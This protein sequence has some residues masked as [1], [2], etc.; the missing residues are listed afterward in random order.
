[1]NLVNVYQ[2]AYTTNKEH[3][4]KSPVNDEELGSIITVKHGNEKNDQHILITI[5]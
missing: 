3:D 5:F 4:A 1:M 2:H